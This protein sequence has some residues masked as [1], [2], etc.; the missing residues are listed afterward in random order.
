MR[1]ST[2]QQRPFAGRSNDAVR[3][4]R[5]PLGCTIKSPHKKKGLVET[6]GVERI[7]KGKM[8]G[9]TC[10]G[11]GDSTANNCNP[12]PLSVVHLHLRSGKQHCKSG[13]GPDDDG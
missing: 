6:S 3:A 9:L 5:D 1:V 11:H 13:K 7:I 4:Q 12:P 8:L 2:E 10:R